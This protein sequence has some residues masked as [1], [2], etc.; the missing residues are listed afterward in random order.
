MQRHGTP[1][2]S[3]QV[4]DSSRRPSVTTLVAFGH[5]EV[6]DCTPKK[7]KQADT[8]HQKNDLSNEETPTEK[9]DKRLQG[10]VVLVVRRRKKPAAV[11]L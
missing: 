3:C 1:L 7:F 10:V 4:A 11:L 8:S 9:E 2:R 6:D 5:A